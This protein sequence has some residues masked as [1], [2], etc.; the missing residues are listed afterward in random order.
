MWE[1]PRSNPDPYPDTLCSSILSIGRSISSRIIVI[2]KWQWLQ[3]GQNEFPWLILVGVCGAAVNA[4]GP[5]RADCSKSCT[6]ER[7][8][9]AST[10]FTPIF[11]R[12]LQRFK[13]QNL[14]TIRTSKCFAKPLASTLHHEVADDY[15]RNQH[16]QGEYENDYE[17]R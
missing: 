17:E 15:V 10:I 1:R 8:T 12:T 2:V 7:A 3:V 14:P 6:W 16:R 11:V 13:S 5:I 9:H 4:D